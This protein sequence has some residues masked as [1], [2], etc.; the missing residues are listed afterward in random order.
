MI[1]HRE[2]HRAARALVQQGQ[3]VRAVE[4]LI[5]ALIQAPE[6]LV[7]RGMLGD[8]YA[9]LG[10]PAPAIECYR[11]VAGTH[12]AAGNLMGAIASCRAIL[13]IDP[14]HTATQRVLAELFARTSA[15][16][17]PVT[18]SVPSAS[19]GRPRQAPPAVAEEALPVVQGVELPTLDEADT[20]ELNVDAGTLPHVPLFS[21]LSRG[22]FL[23]LLPRLELHRVQPGETVTSEGD[24]G[25]SLFVV[26]T[27]T[28]RVEKQRKDGPP[29]V[30]N[31]LGPNTFF[32]EI[33]LLGSGVRTATVVADTAAEL[34]ELTRETL[35]ALIEQHPSVQKVMRRFYRER[36]FSD[37][38]QTSPL[39]RTI[40]S[41]K[42]RGLV[43]R[44]KEVEVDRGT[45]L[46]I[47]GKK[48]SGLHVIL[49]GRC[50]VTRVVDGKKVSMGELTAGA[51]FGSG[52]FLTGE[53]AVTTVTARV[54]TTALCLPPSAA[55]Q[56]LTEHPQIRELLKLVDAQQVMDAAV[57]V[58]GKKKNAS[59][60]HLEGELGQLKPPSLLVF[61]EMER[62]TGVL[63]LE[64]KGN[65]AA[66]F[67]SSGRILDVETNGKVDQPVAKVIEVLGWEQGTFAFSF[68]PVEREDRIQTGTTGLLL[69][70]A[71]LADEASQ[72]P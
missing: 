22:A 51:A 54:R 27:G 6:D 50:E 19:R 57:P 61:F 18:V 11:V 58:T 39:F 29:R 32:G 33:A 40:P 36:L 44:F 20:F 17:A 12:A 4:H 2:L 1:D 45:R 10:H 9:Q 8:L 34:F 31:R 63:R 23:W 46:Q 65:R 37:L 66:L 7:L 35:D 64:Q 55:P 26:V 41:E 28:L 69:E 48:A 43:G 3:P 67:I 49:D 68:E 25:D 15:A 38:V 21:D 47:E 24:F 59:L 5:S 52:S 42:V 60:R 13:A 14:N 72:R 56:L 62:M 70:A 71:R 30:I 16:V 53:P